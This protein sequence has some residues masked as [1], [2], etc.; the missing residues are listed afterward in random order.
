M[1][2]DTPTR[3]HPTFG[4]LYRCCSTSESRLQLAAPFTYIWNGEPWTGASDGHLIAMT[5]GAHGFADAL[6]SLNVMKAIDGSGHGAGVAI[7]LAALRELAWPSIT[8]KCT[9]CEGSGQLE[10]S[11]CGGRGSS[12]CSCYCGNEHKSECRECDGRGWESCDCP[13][14]IRALVDRRPVNI[15]IGRFDLTLFA[16]CLPHVGVDV[17]VWHQSE[18]EKAARID[19]G[20]WIIV[21]MPL[22]Q[23]SETDTDETFPLGGPV[24]S[25][26][27][28]EQQSVSGVSETG[29]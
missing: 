12:D 23:N 25:T 2:A 17:G 8:E 18:P 7:D 26:A 22:R 11:E 10:C 9:A 20:E 28:P 19:A 27:D 4:W 24:P 1:M 13:A 5:R 29:R 16:R 21:L 3:E 14:G 15:G 6:P